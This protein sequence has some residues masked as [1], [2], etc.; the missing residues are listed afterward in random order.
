MKTAKEV[1]PWEREETQKREKKML[2]LIEKEGV[3]VHTLSKEQREEFRTLVKHIPEQYEDLIGV[4]V[5]SKTKELLY[6]KYGAFLENKEHILIGIDADVS[7]G[8]EFAGLEIKRGVELAVQE[9]NDAGGVLNKPFEVVLKNHKIMPSI[10]IQNIKEFAQNPNL[11]ALVGGKHSAVI[12]EE[13]D[14]IQKLQIPYL[15]P[16]AAA[17]K[18]VENG[19]KENYIFRL[20]A[21]DKIASEFIIKYAT[22]HYKKP[23]IMVENSVWG[24][25]NLQAMKKYLQGVGREFNAEVTFNRGAKD[26]DEELNTIVNSGSESLI[27]IAD[28]REGSKIIQEL[29]KQKNPLPVVSHWGIL[30]GGFYNK[31]KKVLPKVD[32]TF[33][34]TYS[35]SKNPTQISNNLLSAYK[36]RYKTDNIKIAYAVAQAYDITKLLAMAIEKAQSTEGEK[37]KEA[38]ENLKFYDGVI[39]K[40]QPAFTHER[41]DALNIE[42][43]CMAKFNAD[44]EIVSVE[45]K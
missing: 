6:K 11:V 9:I 31:N 29:G 13:I 7:S 14:S 20:S 1:T 10:G 22:E 35:F 15:I 28:S 19:Y 26:F 16:W 4:D 17:S 27:L 8:E 24:R 2:E 37:V 18:I 39:K 21:N 12:A 3:R 44:G 45:D 36:M 34:Q 38:L 5:I 41:H 23:A 42:D 33:F 25:E 30:G 43:F 32:L 40:Y